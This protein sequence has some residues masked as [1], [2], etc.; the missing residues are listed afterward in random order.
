[1]LF[2]VQI[3]SAKSVSLARDIDPA[4]KEAFDRALAEGVEAFALTCRISIE[5]IEVGSAIPVLG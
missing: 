4:Y 5:G 3:G 1:M 2:L